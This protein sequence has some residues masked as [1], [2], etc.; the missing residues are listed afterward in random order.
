MKWNRVFITAGIAFLAIGLAAC[1]GSNQA[2][3]G[4]ANPDRLNTDYNDALPVETQLILGTLK[5]EGT[6]QAVD[7]QTA[8]Q[9]LPLYQLLQQLTASG[10]AAQ[11][12]IDTVLEQIQ[13]T[14]TTDQIHAIAAMKLTQTAMTDYFGSSGRY[15]ASGT[16]T[17]GASSG[18]NFPGGGFVVEGGGPPGGFQ[19]GEP[20][21]G[22]GFN[23][24]GES[25]GMNQSQ[26]AT[27]RAQRT[28]TPGMREGGSSTFLITRLIELLQQKTQSLTPGAQTSEPTQ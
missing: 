17:P 19:G 27:L 7:P 28:G 4:T 18:S 2:A 21:A 26:I 6:P 15:A 13:A 8:A 16:R 3:A 25:S 23:G 12:E 22:G 11:A 14:M 9:L 10:T 20:P 1:G 5:L 24:V